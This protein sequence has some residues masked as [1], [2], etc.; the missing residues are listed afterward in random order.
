LEKTNLYID[1]RV[2]IIKF[3]RDRRDRSLIRFDKG[4]NLVSE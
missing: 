1:D 4:I 3:T 2:V